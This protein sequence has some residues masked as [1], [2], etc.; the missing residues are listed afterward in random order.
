MPNNERI[1]DRIFELREYLDNIPD[2]V[3]SVTVKNEL[4]RLEKICEE[5]GI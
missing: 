1:I 3:M 4:K 5:Y 2:G